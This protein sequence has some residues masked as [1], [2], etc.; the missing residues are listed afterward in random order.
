MNLFAKP[1]HLLALTAAVAAL[2]VGT[3][4]WAKP[5][6]PLLN[7]GVDVVSNYSFRGIDVH[8]ELFHKPDEK[9]EPFKFLPAVQPSFTLVGPGGLA[10]GVWSSAALTDRGEDEKTGYKGLSQADEI[11]YTLTWAWE[12]K[13]GSFSS[14]L[15]N[16]SNVPAKAALSEVFLTWGM[17]FAKALAPKLSHYS[18]INSA[19]H[20]TALAIGG[21]EK[22]IWG[23]NLGFGHIQS[24]TAAGPQDLTAKVGY[25]MGA[26]TVS[27]NASYR[28][29][30]KLVAPTL[31]DK[32]GK[33]T[34]KGK[35]EDY[36]P[37]IMWL[38]LSYAGG[39]TE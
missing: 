14:G 28:P 36:P 15:V 30:P 11:D 24:A 4:A 10:V 32:D 2:L 12:N 9:V 26:L 39:V 35:S 6:D 37:L 34:V 27:F 29:T 13:L 18:D 25:V 23:A 31:Y 38:T 22:V 3:S 16:Y 8:Q 1:M 21:G 19:S 5:G 33:Y 7:Y 20:Y 17:P